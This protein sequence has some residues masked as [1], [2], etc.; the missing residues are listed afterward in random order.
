MWS[1]MHGVAFIKK[2]IRK[3]EN[4]DVRENAIMCS[5]C[6]CFLLAKLDKCKKVG[7]HVGTGWKGQ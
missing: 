6:F 7:I 3:E 5:S 2:K 4:I 1:K